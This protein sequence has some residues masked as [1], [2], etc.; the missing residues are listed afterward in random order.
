MGIQPVRYGNVS[1]PIPGKIDGNVLHLGIG[2]SGPQI[3]R[4]DLNG[5]CSRVSF[6]QVWGDTGRN[7]AS[8][9]NEAGI[10]LGSR[11]LALTG[12]TPELVEFSAPGIARIEIATSAADW[13]FVDHFVFE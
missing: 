2:H 4:L 10:L 7:T 9:Y 3:V 1:V 6:Y 5:Q 13:I 12:I 11:D 8:Y